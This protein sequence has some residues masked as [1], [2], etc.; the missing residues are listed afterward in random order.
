LT[1]APA[2][3]PLSV[4]DLIGRAIRFFRSNV[5][6][7][8]KVLLWPTVISI[9]GKVALNW[10]CVVFGRRELSLW[11]PAGCSILFGLVVLLWATFILVLRNLAL[12]RLANGFSSSYE[13]AYS[14]VRRR[15]WVVFALIVC[16]YLM[17]GAVGCFWLVELWVAAL[18]FKPGTALMIAWL[19][20]LV[21]GFCGLVATLFMFGLIGL[22]VLS[23][24]ACEEREF[25]AIGR[26]FALTFNDLGRATLFGML[27]LIIVTSLSY[28]LSL[29][30]VAISMF[31]VFRHNLSSM[32]TADPAR[33]PVY[34]IVLTQAWESIVNMLLWPIT[35]IA[36]GLFY[37]DLRI[38]Q[39]GID[40]L[41]NLKLLQQ[42]GSS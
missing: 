32:A 41:Q 34:I 4:G 22:L 8:V 38:R 28:P 19:L 15:A 10:G 25:S 24:V 7:F 2:T 13:D 33:M 3:T 26:G 37:Y 12:V 35:W 9:A 36:Y 27:V 30:A 6:L 39:E 29:P 21:L 42:S 5:R 40:V 23:V 17:L 16:G 11:V 18:M 20:A 1:E 14:F 31:E